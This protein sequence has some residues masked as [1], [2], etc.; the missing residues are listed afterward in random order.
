MSG[1]DD[2]RAESPIGERI[3]RFRHNVV[4]T[5]DDLAAAADV[6][7]D[8]IRKLEQGQRQTASIASLSRIAR[9]LG[10]GIAALLG[11]APPAASAEQHQP[12]I[13]AIRDALTSVDDILGELDDVDA[14]DLTELARTVIHAWGLYWTCRYATLAAMLPRLLAEAHAGHPRG[15]CGRG[16]TRYRPRRADSPDHRA[17]PGAVR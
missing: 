13:V 15:H 3:R 9:A 16:R 12:Q 6:S 17:H 14:P 4:M 11:P 8:L 10:V 5:Q 2:V 7:T 1:T